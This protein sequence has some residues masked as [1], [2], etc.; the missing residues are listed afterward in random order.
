VPDEGPER[1]CPLGWLVVHAV[2]GCRSISVAPVLDANEAES[3][4]GRRSLPASNRQESAQSSEHCPIP[5]LQGRTCHLPAQDGNLVAEHDDLDGQLVLSIARETDQL[6]DAH[7]SDVEEGARHAPSSS[8]DHANEVQV[9]EPD[10]VLGT[11][12]IRVESSPH[13]L[14]PP[15][16]LPSSR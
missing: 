2:G 15:S 5:W 6:K 14:H 3:P 11:H 1:P 16:L 13:P 12:R 10:D 9:D 8:P 7:E 4:V